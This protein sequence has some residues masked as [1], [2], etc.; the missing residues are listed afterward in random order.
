MH[1][2]LDTP[3]GKSM[4]YFLDTSGGKSMHYFLD[5]SWFFREWVCSTSWILSGVVQYFLD[6]GI[7][8]YFLDASGGMEFFLNTS[9]CHTVLHRYFRGVWSIP[10]ISK[11][12][13][14][15]QHN[16]GSMQY[17]RDTSGICI[18]SLIVTERRPV[19]PWYF[20]GGICNTSWIFM[21]GKLYFLDTSGSMHYFL[22]ISGGY[23][24]V[25]DTS[26]SGYA[27][28]PVTARI[29]LILN[30][31]VNDVQKNRLSP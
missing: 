27:V 20:W 21:G 16:S 10:D 5:T 2:F 13:A 29:V 23:P 6:T 17:F 28:L 14:I 12:Y 25:L 11:G 9:G 8:Q 3:G 4:Q 22:D 31:C 24:V 1:S 18:T 26:G 7:M 15:L 19:L 30:A